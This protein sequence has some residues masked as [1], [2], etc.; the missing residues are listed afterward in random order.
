MLHAVTETHIEVIIDDSNES[1]LKTYLE[2]KRRFL[3]AGTHSSESSSRI[4]DADRPTNIRSLVDLEARNA[5]TRA[6]ALMNSMDKD[7]L[8]RF[9]SLLEQMRAKVES[10]LRRKD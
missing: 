10:E 6:G 2:R 3:E 9:S 1:P 5:M 8:M 7:G 4:L